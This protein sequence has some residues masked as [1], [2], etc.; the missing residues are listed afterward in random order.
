L[1]GLAAETSAEWLSQ[2]EARL[3]V[4]HVAA[5]LAD[6]STRELAPQAGAAAPNQ[7]TG[8]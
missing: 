5:Q 2:A 7:G 3:A 4:E 8:E 6:I 1:D